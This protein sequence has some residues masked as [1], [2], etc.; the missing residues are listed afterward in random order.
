M[1]PRQLRNYSVQV[2]CSW[3]KRGTGGN[4][5]WGRGCHEGGGAVGFGTFSNPLSPDSR[6]RSGNTHSCPPLHPQRSPG[7]SDAEAGMA[8]LRVTRETAT[9][10]RSGGD[11]HSQPSGELGS[12][13]TP[14]E[15][16]F[17]TEEVGSGL[18]L[19]EVGM[20]AKALRGR[21]NP[22]MGRESL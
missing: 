18:G 21:L 19:V 13:Q 16:D 4:Q 2:R 9:E 5:S 20:W 8:P 14:A 1:P 7:T 12:I 6:G 11:D 17:T 22:Q 3:R 15:Q 10:K